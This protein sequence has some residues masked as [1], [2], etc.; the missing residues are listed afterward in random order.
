MNDLELSY[1][2]SNELYFL[3][4]LFATAYC[5]VFWIKPF[6]PAKAKVW[7]IGAVYYITM[8]ILNYMPL[9]IPS[10]AAYGIGVIMAFLAMCL[11]DRSYISQKVFLAA[12][13]FCLRWQAWR[14]VSHLMFINSRLS[15]RLLKDKDDFFWFWAFTIESGFYAV[16]GFLLLYGSARFLLRVYG[17]KREH[18]EI[19][20]FLILLMPCVSS[21]SA[22]SATRFY[23]DAYQNDSG[24]SLSNQYIA[25][26]F[27][28]IL[29]P[30]ICYITILA[31]VYLF[32]RWKNEHE[33][34][35]RKEVFSRQMQDLEAH[36]TETERL[37]KDMRTL[38]HDMG[39]HLMTLKQL[40]AQGEYQAAEEYTKALT[41]EMQKV[42]PKI[43]SGNPVTDVILSDRKK[44]TEE[45]SIDF[46]C[47]FHYPADSG[48]NAFD[49]SI[50]LNNG[51]ANAIEATERENAGH[52]FLSSYRM[53]TMYVI[54][55][56]NSY[57][58]ALE[59]DE[60]SGLPLSTKSGEGHGFG[61][62][63]I[64]HVTKKYLG[65][66]EIKKEQVDGEECCVL[67]VMLQLPENQ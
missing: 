60:Q 25:F 33:E 27:V 64:R 4:T 48:I 20:E 43:Q 8:A 10:V 45:K 35:K 67:R 49:I 17:R 26:D 30:V 63:S 61:L 40:Y 41:C 15:T 2:I 59:T 54:E 39:N 32:R 52:I 62:S 51:L 14:I 28:M 21:I 3:T 31:M 37:Y 29:Y 22:Y 56:T 50:I 6:F 19:W 53:K 36:I 44:E 47:D 34:D 13:F 46:F 58:G 7:A 55:I 12:T 24:K 66:V 9:Y 65:D 18:M 42:S 23:L 16:T 1:Q 38:R 57:K 11:I 5:L